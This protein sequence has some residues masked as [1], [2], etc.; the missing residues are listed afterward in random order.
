LALPA[1]SS[2]GLEGGVAAALE[3]LPD[4]PGVV[5][6][7]AADDR[8]LVVGRGASI[9]AWA[10]SRLGAGPKPKP[11]HRPPL[12][13]S[14]IATTLRFAP[15]ATEFG[16]LL[17][18]ERV[19]ARCVPP[20]PR[21][22]LKPPAWIHV[23]P[24]T[25][26]PRLS[27]VLQGGPGC[28]G[29]FRTRDAAQEVVDALNGGHRLRACDYVF[30]PHPEWPTG[31]QCLFAQ[32][33]SCAAPCLGRIAEGDYRALA[34]EAARRLSAEDVALGLPSWTGPYER[35]A[36]VVEVRAGGG[37]ELYPIAAGVVLDE[38]AAVLHDDL[39]VTPSDERTAPTPLAAFAARIDWTPRGGTDW[40]WLTPWLAS[41]RRRAAWIP[42]VGDDGAR[43]ERLVVT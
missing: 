31:V 43:A 24:A 18:F 9:R 22:D 19:T 33:G 7:L 4:A 14:A 20:P 26:F 34:V 13:L 41:R 36:W 10:A 11:G 15:T 28:F 1:L 35:R 27:V 42:E 30:E 3:A 38:R 37:R 32:V 2:L 23:D 21:P 12:D 25:R 40:P 16:Q 17:L 8:N 6:L 39:T 5:Q 29:P